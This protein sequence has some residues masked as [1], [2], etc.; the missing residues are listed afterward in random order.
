VAD[1]RAARR[2]AQK[3]VRR[4]RPVV[5][6]V[7]WREVA[8][9]LVCAEVAIFVL[10]F[11]PSVLNVFDLTKASFTHAL[12]WGLLGALVVIA[13]GDGL[14]IP[15]SPLFLAF[16]AVVAVEVVTTFT[17]ENQYV[18]IYGEVGRYLGLTTHAV[19][20]LIAVAIAVSI[21]YPRRTSWLAWT[22]GAAAAIAG[23]YAV[24]QA[25]G[26][27]PVQWV[28]ADPR[29]RPFATFGNAD[30]YGQFV[31]VVAMACSAVLVFVRQRPWLMGVTAVLAVF[32]FALMLV[33]Q[34]RGSFVGVAAA[35]VVI[36]PLWLRRAGISRRV[37]ARFALAGAV[38]A[39]VFVV[40]L[41]A[42]P[43]GSRLLDIGR[44]IGLRDRVLLYQSAFQMFVDHPFLGVG[45]EN[46]AVAYPRYQQ[47][48]WFGIAGMNTTNT[49]AHDWILHVAA[50]TGIVGLLANFGLLAAFAVHAW[51]RAR[52]ADAAGILVAATAIAAYYGS[53]LVLPGAQSIQWI[54]WVCVGVALASELRTARTVRAVP[55]L[56]LPAILRLVIVV[57]LASVAF[58]QFGSIEANRS[59]KAA[60]GALGA[61]NASR[62]V[63]MARRATTVDPGRAV[64]WNDL[65]RSL[66]LVPDLAAARGAYRQAT[67]RS[68]YTPAFWWNLA[69]MEQEFAKQNEPGAR[70]AA[71]D[72][73]RRAIAADPQN[74]DTFDRFAKMQLALGDYT[75]AIESEQQAIGLFP[76]IP[77]YYSVAS[78]AARELRDTDS[79]IDFLRRGVAA[80]N[81]N[82]LRITLVRRLIEANRLAE[83]RQVIRDV[84]A[85]DSTNAAALDLQK[86]IGAQ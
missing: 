48:E 3:R 7:F 26:R 84:L 30:F 25:L 35:A 63:D 5:R 67:S 78:E 37:L 76:T 8:L 40:T 24:Q 80:L 16:Y 43:V 15:L 36:A 28:D 55:P 61:G 74:P 60:E 71:Y 9:L 46:F 27:D 42:T 59:A 64:Y 23:L 69:R 44:G 31:A 72:A 4:E 39:A 49:S 58:G 62:A 81:S 53:G 54:P 56:R 45:F 11:D 41:V 1:A 75:G 86:Q 79:A 6:G 57:G 70:D 19:L 17:A 77:G 22:I 2:A 18:A 12:A 38:A 14:R 66:E 33:V 65:G 32:N 68:P 47:A 73:M 82:D 85:T 13:L 51:R 52:D 83:A 29:A 50:T 20:A 34:T 21:D 10:A